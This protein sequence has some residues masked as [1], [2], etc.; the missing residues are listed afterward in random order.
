MFGE[1]EP[2]AATAADEPARDGQE[3]QAEPFRFPAAGVP[4][5]GE[6]LGPGQQLAGQ[7]DD[8]APQLV[9]GEALERQVPQPCVLGAADAVLAASPPPVAEL[10]VGELAAPGVGGE[11]G[12]TV[13]VDVSRPQ[14]PRNKAC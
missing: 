12:E 10:E 11:D 14:P 3:A 13:P 8:L 4:G 7:G 2:Q 6:E 5:Q 1:P 9:L